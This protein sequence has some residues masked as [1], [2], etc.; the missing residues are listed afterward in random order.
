MTKAPGVATSPRLHAYVASHLKRPN[1]C[2][3]MT[4]CAETESPASLDHFSDGQRC[5]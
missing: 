2:R 5:R 4:R 3:E 1:Y